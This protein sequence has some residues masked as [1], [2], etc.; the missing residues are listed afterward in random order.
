[1]KSLVNFIVEALN[2]GNSE[3][4]LSQIK[5][6]IY[7]SKEDILDELGFDPFDKNFDGDMKSVVKKIESSNSIY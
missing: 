6:K 3:L 2:K 7:D 1:M 5:D 4:S